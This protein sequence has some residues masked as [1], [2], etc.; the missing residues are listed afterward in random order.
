MQ[1]VAWRGSMAAVAEP[2]DG[3]DSCLGNGQNQDTAKAGRVCRWAYARLVSRAH[4]R[5]LLTPS[6]PPGGA[7]R[8]SMRTPLR[9]RF[10]NLTSAA[11]VLGRHLRTEVDSICADWRRRGARRRRIRALVAGGYSSAA[12]GKSRTG[13][14]Q[15][16]EGPY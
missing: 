16:P 9:F 1:T 14:K 4:Q 2:K 8:R 13:N 3:L 12:L 15:A 11:V 6:P 10:L 5:E 7:G